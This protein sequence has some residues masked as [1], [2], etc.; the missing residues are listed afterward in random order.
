MKRLRESEIEHHLVKRVERIG[1]IC[2]KFVSP[3][4]VGVPDRLVVLPGGEVIWVELK[5]PGGKVSGPQAR[6]HKRLKDLTQEVKV[7]WSTSQIDRFFPIEKEE[8]DSNGC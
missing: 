1:G 7:F 2:F 4:R 5:S 3:G 6:C 8:P